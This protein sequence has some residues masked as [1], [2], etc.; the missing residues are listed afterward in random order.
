MTEI[1]RQTSTTTENGGRSAQQATGRE[2]NGLYRAAYL[3]YFIFG[4]IE[5]LLVF[6]FV[7]RL[8]GASTASGFVNFIY[9]LSWMFTA[10]F[11]GIFNESTTRG[12]VTG[13]V[14]EPSTIIAF[15]VYAFIAWAI[16]ALIRAI[17]GR[18]VD[19]L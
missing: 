3:V 2:A 18:Q 8:L 19:N 5:V 9:N 12:V 13:S 1:T 7:L 6:R 16:V 17:S 10:P 14:F 4:A 11:T 15:A